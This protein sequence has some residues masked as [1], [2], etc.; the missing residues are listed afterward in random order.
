M[1]PF[2]SNLLA[3]WQ[4]DLSPVFDEREAKN[5]FLFALEDCFNLSKTQLITENNLHLSE[6][7]LAQL[8]AIKTR[9]LAGEPY[10][11]IIGFTYFDRLKIQV[12][13][14]VLIP[15][16]ETEE[17]VDW[18]ATDFKNET[19]IQ[20]V[21][22]CTGS[23]CIGLALKAR[24]P[25]WNITGID[26]S[27]MA[28]AIAQQN[29]RA[30]NLVV[31]WINDDLRQPTFQ[32]SCAVIVSNP[33]YIPIADKQFMAKNVL[34]FEPHLALFVPNDDPLL[35]YRL[36]AENAKKQLVQNGCI[37]LEIHEDFGEEMKKLL[38][39]FGF[40]DIEIR[41]DLQGKF[42]MLKAVNKTV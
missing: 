41:K 4:T 18:I 6:E 39:D 13:P 22:W 29:A 3:T 12:N 42:R 37:Y 35:F 30:N 40:A 16:P 11:Y 1:N 24:H 27:S 34:E 8:R 36:L 38:S 20:L 10:Q 21:D 7:E 14:N 2:F 19:A 5:T 31:S 17:L 32:Q 9:L 23:G 33:P 25:N 15:R 28:L 26:V